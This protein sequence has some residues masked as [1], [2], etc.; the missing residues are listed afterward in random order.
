[1]ATRAFLACLA[2]IA[3]AL[4]TAAHGAWRGLREGR[5]PLLVRRL[6]SPTLYLFAAYLAVA[7]LVTPT[8]PGESSSP[9]LWLA[10][11]LPLAFT[12]AS[13]AA[14]DGASRAPIRRVLLALLH[15]GAVLCAAAIVLALASPAFVPAWLR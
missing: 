7:G 10:L 4:A 13:C 12:L 11:V 3:L 2:W 1:M 15:G 14:L 5:G 9:L 8:S 6:K